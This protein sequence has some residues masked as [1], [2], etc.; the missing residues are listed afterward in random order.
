MLQ[1]FGD[2]NA[3]KDGLGSPDFSGLVNPQPPPQPGCNPL[4]IWDVLQKATIGVKEAGVEAAA[5]TAV[6]LASASSS[7]SSSGMPMF[8]PMVVNRP[9]LFS[10]VDTTGA[11]LFVGHIQDPTNAGGP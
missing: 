3:Y 1:A 5:A 8:V 2:Q 10:I 6:V 11:V 4:E 7:P 9:F